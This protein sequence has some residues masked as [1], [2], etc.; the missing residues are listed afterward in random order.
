MPDLPPADAKAQ[1]YIPRFYLKG[2][3]DKQ[4]TLWVCEK[5]K[6]IRASKPKEEAHRP[7]YYTH[8]ERGH[9]DETAEDALE[10]IESKA[11][12]I[13]RKLANPQYV[14]MPENAAHVIMFVAFMFARVPSWRE[15]LDDLAARLAMKRLQEA[16]SDRER[17]HQTCIE[18]EN[19]KGKSLD[20]DFEQLRQNILDKKFDIKQ[21]SVAFN[22][23]SMFLSGFDIAKQL[24]TM[25]YQALCAPEGKFFVTSDAPVYTLQPDGQGQATIGM[26]FGHPNI[27][28]YF[29][30][31]K[32]ACFRLKT[33]IKP[34]ARIV[35]PE[36]VDQINSITMATATKFSLLI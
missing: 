2:F 36:R 13:V 26:G 35:E 31:H 21:G 10:T 30:L 16:A 12:P 9:R 11:A 20:V 15:N 5:F 14:L 6:P 28:V 27:E 17:F 4:G 32:R 19:A 22:L 18:L 8:S 3:T 23:G 1:H 33:G 7:D 34:M 25:G 24:A 29:P